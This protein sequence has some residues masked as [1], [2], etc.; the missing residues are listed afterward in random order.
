MQLC[1]RSSPALL[2]KLIVVLGSLWM[3]FLVL[4]LDAP[5]PFDLIHSNSWLEYKDYDF[6]PE[7]VCNC[8]A[9]QQANKE[10]LEQAKILTITKEFQKNIQIPDEYYVNETK[11]CRC[12]GLNQSSF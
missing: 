6:G 10:A 3:I 11:D 5:L 2:L 12:V 7:R 9:I 1:K 8:S 4:Q